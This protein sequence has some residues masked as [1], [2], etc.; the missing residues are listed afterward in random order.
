M[1]DGA[2]GL[3]LMANIYRTFALEQGYDYNTLWPF[4]AKESFKGNIMASALAFDHFTRQLARP[5]VGPHYVP[6][7]GLVPAEDGVL[8]SSEDTISTPG[9]APT[10]GRPRP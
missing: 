10:R 9:R 7:R 2:K 1:R 6:A 3:G 5:E 4:I 8:R